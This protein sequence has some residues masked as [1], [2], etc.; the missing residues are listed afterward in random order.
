MVAHAVPPAAIA[1]SESAHRLSAEIST[2]GGAPRFSSQRMT[3]ERSVQCAAGF[4]FRC[5]PG[6]MAGDRS[7]QLRYG[8]GSDGASA[9]MAPATGVG[10][11]SPALT[12]PIR[13][14]RRMGEGWHPRSAA[15]PARVRRRCCR[16]EAKHADARRMA[17]TCAQ[18]SFPGRCSASRSRSTPCLQPGLRR[19]AARV[20]ASAHCRLVDRIALEP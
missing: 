17:A 4:R 2:V 20:A 5:D 3:C 16:R 9:P 8:A 11:P 14:I 7:F 19:P 13:W 15:S 12:W 10:R 6:S 1:W 18:F